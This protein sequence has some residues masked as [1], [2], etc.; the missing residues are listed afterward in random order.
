MCQF[1][2]QYAILT[3]RT[4]ILLIWVIC[5]QNT[6]CKEL[7][8][9]KMRE[10]QSCPARQVAGT[11]SIDVAGGTGHERRASGCASA[12]QVCDGRVPA[13]ICARVHGR[14]LRC[15]LAS[16]LLPQVFK[17]VFAP[18]TREVILPGGFPVPY[19]VSA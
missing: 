9:C 3:I 4:Q 19:P 12:H 18:A 11:Y 16:G 6:T 7:H 10:W 17:V 15:H 2:A 14:N 8:T 13:V 5:A 1:V